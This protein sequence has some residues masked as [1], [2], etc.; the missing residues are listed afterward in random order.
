MKKPYIKKLVS[1]NGL[2]F[3][4]VDGFWIRKNIEEEFTNCSD[5]HKFKFIPKN[6]VWIDKDNNAFEMKYFIK[7]YLAK[8]KYL[9]L[10]KHYKKAVKLANLIEKNERGK[11][12]F[13]RKL[14]NVSNEQLINKIHKKLLRKY[15]NDKVK[16]WIVDGFLVRSLIFLDF[17]HGGHDFVYRFVPKNEVWIDDVISSKDLKYVLVH[18]LRERR[19]MKKGMKYNNAHY[20]FASK[21]ELYLRK[22]PKKLDAILRKEVEMQT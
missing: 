13:L 22:N 2:N 1:K 15:S 12:I 19:L 7:F 4:I 20:N 17:T 16:T 6:E 21:I 8:E 14:K 10:G 5:F 9:S 18:E 11:N 3:F